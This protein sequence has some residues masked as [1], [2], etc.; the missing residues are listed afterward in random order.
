M[1][2]F[3]CSPGAPPGGDEVTR[4]PRGGGTVLGEAE[5]TTITG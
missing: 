4:D 2:R 1:R 3:M 5:V